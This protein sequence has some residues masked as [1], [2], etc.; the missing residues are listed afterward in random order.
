MLSCLIYLTLTLLIPIRLTYHALSSH[1]DHHQARLWAAYWA[2]YSVL[3]LLRT[4]LPFLS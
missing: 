2:I 4:H 1:D 3:L